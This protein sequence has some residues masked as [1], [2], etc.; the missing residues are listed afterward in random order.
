MND[1]DHFAAAA[2]TGLVGEC[3]YHSPDDVA[4][5]AYALAAAMLRERERTTHG[6]APAA[7]A[8]TDADRDRSDKAAAR[9]GEGT[10]DIPCSRTRLSEAEIDALEYVVVE[11]RISCVEDYGV[12]RSLL[13]RVRPEWG[14]SDSV[15][16]FAKSETDSPQP[17]ERTTPTQAPPGANRIV[18]DTKNSPA[19]WLA[20]AVDGSESSA[21]YAMR[22]QAEAAARE[23]GWQIVPLYPFPALWPEDEIAIEAAWERTGLTPTWPEDEPQTSVRCANAMADEIL[24]L[25]DGAPDSRETVQQE[26]VAWAVVF[27]RE[28]EIVYEVS[29]QPDQ[30]A[31]YL[32]DVVRGRVV[33][34]YRHP[35]PT[36]TDAETLAIK[37][38]LV[39]LKED[40]ALPGIAEDKES[41]RGLLARLS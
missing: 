36:L 24:R 2:L 3:G 33:P 31:V 23:W 25:R 39:Y 29:T 38:A 41:L 20:V 32:A 5:E 8:R 21:V 4:G 11:G 35:Q 27:G 9:P 22:E 28:H 17:V 7:T 15:S 6:A 26:P 16:P 40:P 1:R 14:A 18:C 30:A 34:L 12:L 19:A 37:T 10:G 13:V